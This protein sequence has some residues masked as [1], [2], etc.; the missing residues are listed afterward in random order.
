MVR[1]YNECLK[2]YKSA[3]QIRKAID[4]GELYQIEKGIYADEPKASALAIIA[5]KYPK[6]IIT[7]DTAFYFH[8]L[9]DVIPDEYCIATRE[10]SRALRDRRVK[11]F[12]IK[13]EILNIGV[14]TMERQGTKFKIYD[15]ERMLV[16]LLR[17]KKQLPFDYYKEV[18]GNYRKYIYNLDIERIQEY[19][20]IFPR[21]KMISEA[22]DAE[23][24]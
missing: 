6:A 19:A 21:H 13:D 3:Y 10:S 8:G 16:E 17:F 9:T 18:L 2:S 15:R 7:M 22:L 4:T 14:T 12:F 23:V 20:S 5:A 1:T 24:F 11:Q